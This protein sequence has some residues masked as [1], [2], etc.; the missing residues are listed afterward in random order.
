YSDQLLVTPKFCSPG[1][2][3]PSQVRARWSA[4]AFL[5]LNRANDPDA[6]AALPA[7]EAWRNA[8][9]VGRAADRRVVRPRAAAQYPLA[10]RGPREAGA[11]VPR[12]V[13]I[14]GIPHV[15]AVLPNIAV[16]VV[17]TKPVR[18]ECPRRRR[19]ASEDPSGAFTIGARFIPLVAIDVGGDALAIACAAYRTAGSPRV[20]RLGGDGRPAVTRPRLAAT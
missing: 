10:V 19:L 5:A 7:R 1:A 20:P 12:D 9:A 6:D 18:R 3:R 17:E 2:N 4:V 13:G 8:V 14:V 11:A 15:E 16:H